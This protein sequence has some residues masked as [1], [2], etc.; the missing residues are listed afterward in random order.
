MIYLIYRKNFCN[1]H[2]IPLPRA[3]I[4]KKTPE[5]QWFLKKNT[6]KIEAIVYV[7][8]YKIFKNKIRFIEI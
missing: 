2:N 8:S 7:I 1:C 4:K 5:R 6:S 3:T